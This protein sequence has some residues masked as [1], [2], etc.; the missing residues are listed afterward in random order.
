MKIF[1]DL[2]RKGLDNG[3]INATELMDIDF[4][5]DKNV[6]DYFEAIDLLED[7]GIKII[8]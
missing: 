6:F 2:L 8:Y 4:K 5:T 7:R 1:E 3:F